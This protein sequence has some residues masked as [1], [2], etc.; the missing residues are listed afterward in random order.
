M[1]YTQVIEFNQAVTEPPPHAQLRPIL[2]KNFKV[3]Q[4]GDLGGEIGTKRR[5]I[6]LV[7][8]P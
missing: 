8:T 2:G 6:G 3:P 7:C 1:V 5:Q 4:A